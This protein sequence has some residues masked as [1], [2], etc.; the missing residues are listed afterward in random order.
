MGGVALAL[1]VLVAVL[2]TRP[3]TQDSV[4]ASPLVGKTAPEISGVA[5]DGTPYRLS[6]NRGHFVLVNFFAGWCV[7]CRTEEPELVQLAFEHRSAADL[8]I[9]GV[10]FDEPRAD[11][12]AYLRSAGALWPGIADPS[13]Q[14]ALDYGVRGPPESFLVAPDGRVVAK[15]VGGVTRS[16]VDSLVARARAE[17]A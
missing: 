5:F 15:V 8:T 16:G 3:G 10:A 13:G 11:A 2:A 14:I 4:A 9:V 12:A 1:I 6:A 7:P 17:G